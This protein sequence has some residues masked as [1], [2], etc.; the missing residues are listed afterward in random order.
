MVIILLFSIG[1][2]TIVIFGKIFFSSA[3][4]NLFKDHAAWS[5]RDI[6]LNY[7]KASEGIETNKKDNFLKMIAEQS[8]LYLEEQSN[9]AEE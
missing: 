1:I 2:A 6:K 8:D 4:K 7:R 5:G 9:T 3:K